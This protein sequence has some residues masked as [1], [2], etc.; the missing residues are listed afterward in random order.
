MI[1]HLPD[2]VSIET[3]SSLLDLNRGVLLLSQRDNQYLNFYPHSIFFFL[4]GAAK[5]TCVQKIVRYRYYRLH[6]FFA[7]SE[8]L[9]LSVDLSVF[10]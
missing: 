8:T 4:H 5:S 2:V 7:L 3:S 1:L 9:I 10:Y 6:W